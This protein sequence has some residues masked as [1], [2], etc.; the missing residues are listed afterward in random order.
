MSND[1]QGKRKPFADTFTLVSGGSKGIGR[2][3]ALEIARLG[4]SVCILARNEESV[5]ET[6]QVIGDTLISDKQFV[7]TIVCDATDAEQL[8]PMIDAL[9]DHRGVPDYLLNV[10]GY[11][12]PKHFTDLTLPDFKKNMDINYYGQLVPTMLMV[13]YMVKKQK[14]HVSFVSSIAGF[15]GLVG[16][17]SYSPTK[18]AVVGLAEVLRHELKPKNIQISMLYPPDTDT[19]GFV[20]ENKTKPPE[21]AILSETAKLYTPE[22]VAVQYV[23]GLLKNKMHIFVGEGRWIWRLF[24]WFP[25]LVYAIMDQD[26]QKA[27]IKLEQEDGV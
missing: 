17:A 21:T 14:G 1:K 24:R 10:V 12:Y 11:A 5:L 19:P 23:Q 26:H 2:A 7:E 9:V 16:Y 8:R 13:P 22:Q 6:A 20:E 4:G 3:T 18:F 27:L 25:G 15:L